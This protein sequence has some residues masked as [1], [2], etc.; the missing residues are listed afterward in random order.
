MHYQNLPHERGIFKVSFMIS[1][2]LILILSLSVCISVYEIY[3]V[4]PSHLTQTMFYVE[5]DSEAANTA[6]CY[7]LKSGT[8]YPQSNC[9]S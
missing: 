7:H 9:V 2:Q 8:I 1:F 6:H 3:S 4:K 5:L